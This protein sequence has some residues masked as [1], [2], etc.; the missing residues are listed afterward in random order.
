MYFSKCKDSLHDSDYLLLLYV[1][2]KKIITIKLIFY[3][4]YVILYDTQTFWEYFLD[5]TRCR[6]DIILNWKSSF[7]KY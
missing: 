4:I 6:L 2:K 5:K 1:I 3:K 7:H